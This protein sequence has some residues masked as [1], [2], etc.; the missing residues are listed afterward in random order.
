MSVSASAS[1]RGAFWDQFRLLVRYPNFGLLWSGQVIS[2][3]GDAFNNIALIWLVQ[4]MTGSRTMMGAVSAVVSATAL[5]G[6]VAGALVDRWDRRLTMF[7]SD[8]LRG[9]LVAVIPLLAFGG[10]LQVWQL[11]VVAFGMGLLAQLFNPAKQA[12]IPHLVERDDLTAA[13]ALSHMAFTLLMALG[14]GLGGA[15]LG[16][17]AAPQIFA[18]DALTFG[19]SAVTIWLIRMPRSAQAESE[20]DASAHPGDS[21]FHQI[22]R[23]IA[24]GLRFM[25]DDPFIRVTIPVALLANFIFAPLT[26]LM[27]AWAKDIIVAGAQGYGLLEGGF[28]IGSLI[29]TLAATSLTARFQRGRLIIGGVVMMGIPLIL[30]AL[31]P[32]LVLNVAL[33]A[34]IGFCNGIVNIILITLFQQRVPDAMMGRFFGAFTGLAMLAAPLGVALGGAL[35]DVIPISYLLTVIGL[36]MALLGLSL[37]RRRIVVDLV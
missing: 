30:F 22:S 10:N 8:I 19:V 36:I 5:F 4:E 31:I 16:I 17:L 11:F 6:L 20:P 12:L 13:N 37:L 18:V 29:G 28:L 26:V 9:A 3:L 24:D 15:L 35:A 21:A 1:R 2:H 33:I 32:N 27:A 7:W 34:L 25:R 14:Y 23:D